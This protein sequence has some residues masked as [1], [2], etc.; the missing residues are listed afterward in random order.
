VQQLAIVVKIFMVLPSDP[1]KSVR[2]ESKPEQF[3]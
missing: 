2:P 1:D 3:N